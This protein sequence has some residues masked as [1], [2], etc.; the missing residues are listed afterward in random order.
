MPLV[1]CMKLEP[2]YTQ[3]RYLHL[4]FRA[5]IAVPSK[6][7]NLSRSHAQLRKPIHAPTTASCSLPA[8]H[9]LQGLP[10]TPSPP[11]LSH[12]LRLGVRCPPLGIE[13]GGSMQVGLGELASG[14]G[15]YHRRTT[16]DSS[17]RCKMRWLHRTRYAQRWWHVP[18]RQYQQR[19]SAPKVRYRHPS[20]IDFCAPEDQSVGQ[21]AIRNEGDYYLLCDIP[22]YEY[23]SRF[24]SRNHS[25]G[26]S[27]IC[28]PDP[29]DLWVSKWLRW[30]IYTCRASVTHLWR[31]TF[32]R[33]FEKPRYALLH[34]SRPL[35]IGG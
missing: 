22:V 3:V 28:T 33:L 1:A 21:S 15:G 30:V 32:C 19:T 12:S 14:R 24:A 20:G 31:L 29:K 35:W 23:I 16:K 9:W 27:R 13:I 11:A 17:R 25:L 2:R 10:D 18:H 5:S 4:E 34:V 7:P 8:K 6:P 26:D